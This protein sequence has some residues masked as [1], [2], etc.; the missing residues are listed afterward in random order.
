[1]KWFDGIPPFKW[2]VNFLWK[3]MICD[4][5]GECR[6]TNLL[7]IGGEDVGTLSYEEPCPKLDSYPCLKIDFTNGSLPRYYYTRKVSENKF[8][9]FVHTQDGSDSYSDVNVLDKGYFSQIFSSLSIT[10]RENK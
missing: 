8:L 9:S 5:S 4:G 3:G 10:I 1:M 7:P 2:V 6:I